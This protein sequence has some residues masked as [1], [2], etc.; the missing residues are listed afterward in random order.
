MDNQRIDAPDDISAIALG[1]SHGLLLRTN[2][3]ILA[4]GDRSNGQLGDGVSRR[5]IVAEALGLPARGLDVQKALLRLMNENR[6]GFKLGKPG[7]TAVPI[8][9]PSITNAIAIAAAGN[10]SFAVLADGSVC[11]WGVNH[12]GKLCDGTTFDS[13]KPVLSLLTNVVGANRQAA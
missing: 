13:D 8:Q 4:W 6:P 2:G 5:S 10:T 11:A 12:S 1:D 3:T 7:G 9:V